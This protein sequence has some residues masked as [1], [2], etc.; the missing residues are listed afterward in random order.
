MLV[1]NLYKCDDFSEEQRRLCQATCNLCGTF[2]P[3]EEP[4]SE[5]PAPAIDVTKATSDDFVEL[6]NDVQSFNVVG[7]DGG[8]L[9]NHGQVPGP[10]NHPPPQQPVMPMMPGY[11]MMPM[12]PYGHMP[13]PYP[14]MAP[15]MIIY[16]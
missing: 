10:T 6:D 15:G 8:V 3:P 11:P 2:D 16:I 14:G 1:A 9:P 7:E 12:N 5:P 4:K 13:Y